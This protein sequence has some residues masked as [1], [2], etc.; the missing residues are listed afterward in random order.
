MA[1]RLLFD[2]ALIELGQLPLEEVVTGVNATANITTANATVS[3]QT[4]V[5]VSGGVVRTLDTASVTSTGEVAIVG[6]LTETLPAATVGSTA[7]LRVEALLTESLDSATI[8]STA[9]A[10]VNATAALI[11]DSTSITGLGDVDVTAATSTALADAQ[12]DSTTTTPLTAQ[13]LRTLDTA[14]LS[15]TARNVVQGS[16]VRTLDSASVL[17]VSVAAV[18][19]SLAQNI[20][21]C[22]VASDAAVLVES[23]VTTTLQ[24]T[25]VVSD[26]F[27]V[28]PASNGTLVATLDSAVLN[29]VSAV[30]VRAQVLNIVNDAAVSSIGGTVVS[31]TV[32]STLDSCGVGA[33]GYR[34]RIERPNYGTGERTFFLRENGELFGPLD[35]RTANSQ[36]RL[37]SKLP[38]RSGV[39]EVVTYVGARPGD[40]V[41]SPPKLQVVF[42]YVRGKQVFGGRVAQYQSK[43]GVVLPG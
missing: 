40:P 26:G 10:I 25:A 34:G 30:E 24:D 13:V 7:A 4:T 2:G 22:G 20:A 12:V 11:L 29:S 5:L 33:R 27:V 1:R 42:I 19:G 31:S 6:G 37:I 9:N 8:N 39:V 15:S 14:Q 28:D 3:A 38:K 43:R 21:D 18:S 23:V 35:Y 36:A 17:A 32:N 41:L 16:T